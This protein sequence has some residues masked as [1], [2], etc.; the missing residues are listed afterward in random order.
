MTAL[1]EYERLESSGVWSE[2]GSAQKREVVVAFGNASL[3][4]RDKNEEPLAHWS[5]PAVE[6]INPGKTPA[7]YSPNPA[8]TETLQVDDPDMITAIERV[9]L[10]I[11][12][13]SP[14]PGRL[15]LAVFAITLLTI[16][17]LTVFWLPGALVR[18][19]S[20]IVPVE[21]RQ[22]VGRQLARQ[23]AT[24]TGLP[25]TTRPGGQALNR[26]E[27]RLFPDG[28]H[29]LAIMSAGIDG[30]RHLPGGMILLSKSLVEDFETVEVVAG[31]A[32]TEAARAD[33]MDPLQ[34]MLFWAGTRPTLGLL[35]TGRLA[36]ELNPE[37][38]QHILQ[39][40]Q[41]TPPTDQLIRRFSSASV[42]SSPYAYAVDVSGETTIGLI[43][44]DPLRGQA[45]VPLMSDHDWV[46]LQDI[47]GG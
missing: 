18:H 12:K 7:F 15:R 13:N 3:V 37:Y 34:R 25:C 8:G 47:C 16:G 1:Q 33:R 38:A 6:R 10:A 31:Y 4:I 45:A 35:T 40:K 19:T 32:L 14:H 11:R 26:L 28:S 42:S 23:I 41:T 24:L 21:K 17:I 5:L 39:T 43:E 29:R 20:A 22:Q 44:A 9:R 30:S 46:A 2:N 27:A 36:E